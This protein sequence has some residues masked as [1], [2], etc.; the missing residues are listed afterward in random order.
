[1]A[2]PGGVWKVYTEG[3][4]TEEEIPLRSA[5]RVFRAKERP[6]VGQLPLHPAQADG[7]R[8]CGAREGLAPA[9]AH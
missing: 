8:G 5:A 6:G 3:A 1:M 4:V 7:G 2:D 9:A